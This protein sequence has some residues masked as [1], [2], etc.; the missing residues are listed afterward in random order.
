MVDKQTFQGYVDFFKENDPYK[1]P[2][3]VYENYDYAGS[4]ATLGRCFVIHFKESHPELIHAAIV[5]MENAVEK[6]FTEKDEDGQVDV[7]QII[8]GYNDL[9]V[10]YG[11][12]LGD[13]ER[14]LHF[15]NKGLEVL[16][17]TA[18]HDL[19]FGVRGQ[20]WFNR[21][22]SMVR[23]GREEEALKEC[24]EKIN[25]TNF[26]NLNYVSNSMLY[27]GYQFLGYISQRRE[28]YL[29]AVDHLEKGAQFLDLQDEVRKGELE[30]FREILK[31]KENNPEEC[32]KQ[33]AELLGM[34]SSMHQ[35][36]DY[37]GS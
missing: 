28:D 25:E 21:W 6:M 8:W 35:A 31:H 18:D 15:A 27:Y 7:D 17:T 36:W 14:A 1:R 19:H 3:M 37:D 20:L 13:M 16:Q 10:W 2:S 26:K 22:V 24:R 4:H 23:L 30:T 12:F 11:T 33:V 9:S 34:V 5:L 29:Q 32:Y